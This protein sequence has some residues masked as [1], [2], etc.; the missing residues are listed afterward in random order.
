MPAMPEITLPYFLVTPA[1]PPPWPGI[2][3][4]HE[5]NGMSPQL[6]RISERIAAEGL[7]VCAPDFFFRAGGSEAADFAT[8]MGSV[9]PD[10]LRADLTDAI[11][12]LHEAG[13]SSIGIT[14]FCMGG[15]FAYRAATYDIGV[16]AAVPFYGGFIAKE[17]GDPTC[18]VLMFFG[19]QDE[20]VP[21]SDV[22]KV[23]D[24][25]PDDVV[26]YPQA[27]HGFMRD[28][29]PDYDPDAAADAWSRMLA[30]FR[31]HLG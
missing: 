2:I 23:R 11:A 19:G 22:E 6:L 13:A 16:E 18:P 4:V 1:S 26:V 7:A 12:V 29:S 17:L 15:S 14:G 3:V 21:M 31:E 20:Y 24:R 9:T 5:G 28:G 8:L 25:H 10:S 27:K 30:F